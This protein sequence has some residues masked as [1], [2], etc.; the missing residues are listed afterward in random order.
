MPGIHISSRG[1]SIGTSP[2][3]SVIVGACSRPLRD[4]SLKITL[5]L[6]R[7]ID[8][9]DKVAEVVLGDA[10]DR[11]SRAWLATFKVPYSQCGCY[12]GDLADIDGGTGQAIQGKLKFWNKGK[13]DQM[14]REMGE[15]IS[16]MNQSERD[17]SHP[18][19][20]NLVTVR[21]EHREIQRPLIR[22]TGAD[23]RQ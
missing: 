3:R 4:D 1:R 17:S 7:F 12:Q 11:T 18:S 5:P 2:L 13:A 8:H 9:D 23:Y 22:Y 21:N 16:A 10:Y 6:S 14:R 19:V 20:H 15:A